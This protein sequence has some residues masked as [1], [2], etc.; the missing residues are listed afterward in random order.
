MRTR[1][2]LAVLA[3]LS[4]SFL[5]PAVAAIPDDFVPTHACSVL[6]ATHISADRTGLV[7]CGLNTGNT[8]DPDITCDTGGG[9]TWMSMSGGG[10]SYSYYCYSSASLGTPVCPPS[11]T[12]G[13]Q[14]PCESGY[15]VSRASGSWGYIPLTAYYV[16]TGGHP[17]TIDGTVVEYGQEYICS[18]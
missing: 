3:L 7:I 14:G 2:V 12:I 9:C 5:T 18:N 8:D 13:T 4:V 1:L 6:G 16:P 17:A 11:V 10:V 15:R